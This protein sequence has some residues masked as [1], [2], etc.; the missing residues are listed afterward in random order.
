ML[1]F[2]DHLWLAKLAVVENYYREKCEQ[3]KKWEDF[4]QESIHEILSDA[5]KLVR[6]VQEYT[7]RQSG[8]HVHKDLVEGLKH[9]PIYAF[10]LVLGGQDKISR[11]QRDLL[12]LYFSHFNMPYTVDSFLQAVR[13]DN[14]ARKAF[15][16]LIGIDK[17]KAG[18][19]WIQ[20]YKLLYRTAEDTKPITDLIDSFCRIM[21][22]FAAISHKDMDYLIPLMK[23]FVEAVHI[24]ADICWEE[25]DDTIDFYG[26]YSFLEHFQEY[27]ESS[28][29]VCDHTMDPDDESLNP[30]DFFQAFT[31]GI[32]YQVI[33]RCTRNR[34]D[35]IRILDDVLNQCDI[36]AD[37][38]GSYVF[39]Y[40]EDV[41]GEDTSM[42]AAMA[43]ML[44]DPDVKE[45]VGW[46]ILARASGTYNLDTNKNMN[47]VQDAINFI[48]G[49]E[50]YLVDKYPMSGFGDVATTYARKVMDIISKDIDMNVTIV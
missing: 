42:L 40:L 7:D 14:T 49:M 2:W 25:P 35:K 3:E 38:D 17:E 32:I 13:S 43:Q 27:K 22:R 8:I 48:I 20:F 29:A 1:D 21:M 16:E 36:G 28:Y 19:F 11:E 50:N 15:L 18:R 9:L 37:V 46:I 47:P 24:Q 10:Y 23:S 33:R 30:T 6:I 12:T 4:C 45:C 39:K 41:Q 31:I 34:S 44:T 5:G 26:D